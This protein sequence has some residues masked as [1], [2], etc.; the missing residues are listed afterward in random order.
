MAFWDYIEKL[1][2]EPEEK[3]RAILWWSTTLITLLIVLIWLLSWR[4]SLAPVDVPETSTSTVAIVSENNSWLGNIK[5]SIITGW[6]SLKQ[7]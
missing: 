5:L 7:N 6:Q 1:R 4:W 3:R 2:Q